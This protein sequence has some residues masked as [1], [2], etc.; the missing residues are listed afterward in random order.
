M[1]PRIG[2]AWIAARSAASVPD[3]ATGVPSGDVAVAWSAQ[4]TKLAYVGTPPVPN[5]GGVVLRLPVDARYAAGIGDNAAPLRACLVVTPW[6]AAQ[7]MPWDGRPV[8]D[9][10]LQAPGMWTPASREYRFDVTALA[11]AADRGQPSFGISVEPTPSPSTPFDAAFLHPLY[12]VA[13]SA[14]T[15]GLPM[16]ATG[17]ASPPALASSDTSVTSAMPLP[18]GMPL[19]GQVPAARVAPTVPAPAVS[20][21]DK[22]LAGD[23]ASGNPVDLGSVYSCVALLGLLPALAMAARSGARV[24]P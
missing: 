18:A 21:P 9:C 15:S 11:A 16:T 7:P 19:L 20:G 5:A 4:P 24:R 22:V 17:S 13:A 1:A 6:V 23:V 8:T 3:T 2:W 14:S 12:D 10:T